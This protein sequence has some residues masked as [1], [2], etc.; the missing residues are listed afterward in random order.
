MHEPQRKHLPETR[1]SITHKRSVCG[2]EVYV[3][4]SFYDNENDRAQ[5]AE[6]FTKL[7]K[8]GTEMSGL[9]DGFCIM[10]SVSLQYGVPWAKIRKKFKGTRFGVQTADDTSLLDGLVKMVD[11]CIDTRK[12]IIGED[13]EFDSAESKFDPVVD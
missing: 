2:F 9:L 5:P 6:V 7:A 3:I 1:Q 4:V 12:Q 8:H 11:Y 13:E 10:V